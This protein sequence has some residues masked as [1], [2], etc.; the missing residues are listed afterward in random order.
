V[1][2]FTEQVLLALVTYL[3][4]CEVCARS[5]Q[6]GEEVELLV[7]LIFL[8]NEL[9]FISKLGLAAAYI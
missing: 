5:E 2:G 1:T 7:L 3:R 4:I 6:E 8:T 9:E